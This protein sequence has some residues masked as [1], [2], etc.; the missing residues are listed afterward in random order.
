MGRL[1]I[2]GNSFFEID[3]ECMKKK[4]IPK[5]CNLDK[6]LKDNSFQIN[7]SKNIS[8]KQKSSDG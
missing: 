4:K 1:I 7:A 8:K 3:E 2:D 5:R 6:Y